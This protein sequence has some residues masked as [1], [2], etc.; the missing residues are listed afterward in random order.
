MGD[1]TELEVTAAAKFVRPGEA[2]TYWQLQVQ[3]GDP[4]KGLNS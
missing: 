4:R 2:I 1:E 3:P